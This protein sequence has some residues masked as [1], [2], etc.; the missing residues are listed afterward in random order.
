MVVFDAAG[1]LYGAAV[2]GGDYGV[3][4]AFEITP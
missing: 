2:Y 4:S 1:N 3:G